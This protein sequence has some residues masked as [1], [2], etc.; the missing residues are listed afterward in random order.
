MAGTTRHTVCFLFQPR[1]AALL[2]GGFHRLFP[3]LREAVERAAAGAHGVAKQGGGVLH[4]GVGVAVLEH[5]L[6]GGDAVLGLPCPGAYRRPRERLPAPGAPHRLL[7]RRRGE[8]RRSAGFEPPAGGYRP[9]HRHP[10]GG[11][12]RRQPDRRGEDFG[13]QPDDALEAFEKRLRFLKKVLDIS[14]RFCYSKQAF[15]G[16]A[17][18]GALPVKHAPP[19]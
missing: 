17:Q 11:G 4:D 18:L 2:H 9:G 13:H 12:G 6:Q 7:H 8:R 1:F 14:A 15:G 3:L 16:I 5:P 10:R 19:C